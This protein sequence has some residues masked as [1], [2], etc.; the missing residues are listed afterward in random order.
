MRRVVCALLCILLVMF[1]GCK[2]KQREVP[3]VTGVETV[4]ARQ[5]GFFSTLD[6][7]GHDVH[8]YDPADI[9]HGDIINYGYTAP[10]F[11]VFGEEKLDGQAAVDFICEKGIDKTAQ[12]NGAAVVYVNPL[13]SWDKE[14][15]GVYERILALTRLDQRDFAH[16]LLYDKKADK[17]HLFNSGSKVCVYGYGTGA[18]YIAKNYLKPLSGVAAMSYITGKEADTTITAAVLEK[19][20]VQPEITDP[21][22]IIVSVNNS[23]EINKTLRENSNYYYS[24][25]DKFGKIYEDYL[26][27]KQRADG[28]IIETTDIRDN[29][30]IQEVQIMEITRSED[31]HRVKT[32]TYE[33]GAVIYRKED[34]NKKQRPLVLCFHGG[35]DTAILTATIS[36][37]TQIALEED[38]ILCAIENHVRTTPTEVMEVIDN[39]EK[40][41]DIDS[42]RIYATGFSMGSM[43]TWDLYQEYPE[44][45]AAMSPMGGTVRQGRNTQNWDSPKMNEDVMVPV[46]MVG[47]ESS[48]MVELPFQGRTPVYRVEYLFRVNQVDNPFVISIDRTNWPDSIY[49]YEGDVVE[50]LTDETHPRSV[51]T[52]RYYKSFDGNFYTVLCS[53]SHHDHEIRPF[54]C[55]IAWDFMSQFRR[56][57][58]GSISIIK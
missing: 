58:D 43:K 38:F 47:G 31:N 8:V 57:S 46:F 50:K 5:G 51:T 14:P 40:L 16:G 45:F 20:S 1:T 6:V 35:G 37:W 11:L 22:I 10:M 19:L 53:I 52:L 23:S 12:E 54:T 28:K 3:L 44:R 2:E 55:Q 29:G 13:T 42:T 21:E 41:Y 4:E 33:L 15:Y 27:L 48:S 25:Q 18:D 26:R 34:S 9:L 49:G 7:E 36:G 24:S 56:N 39:L 32:P 30:L 17:Y